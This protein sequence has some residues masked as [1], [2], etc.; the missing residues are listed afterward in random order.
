MLDI[1]SRKIRY[2]NR[3]RRAGDE[4]ARLSNR[5]LSDL[6]IKRA[7]IGAHIRKHLK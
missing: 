3:V 2:W 6:G 1:I 7:E 5:E 4:F